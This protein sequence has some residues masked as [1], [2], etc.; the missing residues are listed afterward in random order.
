MDAVEI[1]ISCPNVKEGGIAFGSSPDS[2]G[3]VVSG[4]RSETRLPIIAKVP[5]LVSRIEDV[6]K[7]ACD[8]GADALTIANTY[9]A[10]AIDIEEARPVLG[11][12][13]GG[14]SGG[15]IRPMSLFLVWKVASV[16]TV[17]I[18]GG[19]GIEAASDA[20]EFMLAGACSFQIGTIVL[21]DLRAPSAILDGLKSY[22]QR[23]GYAS[24]GDFVGRA[25]G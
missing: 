5:P 17:P 19:G 3:L 6:C 22:M 9:P 7:A 15:A 4:V 12:I 25:N 21:K 20:V 18:I 11:G 23:N 24:P 1:N 8:A 13:T 16:V 14:L 10:M 2:T